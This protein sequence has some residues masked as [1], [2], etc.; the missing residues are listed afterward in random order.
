MLFFDIMVIMI[1]IVN[2]VITLDN[3]WMIQLCT[4]DE[5]MERADRWLIARTINGFA[6]NC[7][8]K[9]W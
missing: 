8:A 6:P 9:K 5:T 3:L 4:I 7:T 1:I 2:M